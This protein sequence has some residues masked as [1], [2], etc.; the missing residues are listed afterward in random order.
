VQGLALVWRYLGVA[1]KHAGE[2]DAVTHGNAALKLKRRQENIFNSVTLNVT[3][4]VK[5]SDSSAG[6]YFTPQF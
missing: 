2:G 4:D 1:E 5:M 6:K 3:F